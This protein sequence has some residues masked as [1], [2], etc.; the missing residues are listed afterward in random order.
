MLHT[1]GIMI[2]GRSTVLT[3]DV[4]LMILVVVD[5]MAGRVGRDG[6]SRTSLRLG[7]SPSSCAW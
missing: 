1:S 3:L 4:A 5:I 7:F 6:L 2:G